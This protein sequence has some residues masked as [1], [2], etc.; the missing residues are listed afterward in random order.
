[1]LMEIS[2]VD[3][4]TVDR[5]LARFRRW[6][7][8]RLRSKEL[9]GLIVEDRAHRPLGSGCLWIAH[10]YPRLNNLGGVTPYILSVFVEPDRRRGGV[11][12]RLLRELI[13]KG[14]ATGG[15]RIRLHASAQGRQLYR[16]LGFE[17][18][19]EMR[20]DLYDGPPHP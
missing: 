10:D 16:N 17:R 11:A 20:L 1:M 15:A 18:T 2:G 6:M 19:W 12:T 3:G 5:Y 4:P 8:P 14:R 9:V 13:R 7:S